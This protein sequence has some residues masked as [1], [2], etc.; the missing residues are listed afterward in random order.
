MIKK[1]RILAFGLLIASASIF[2]EDITPTQAKSS[3][4]NNKVTDLNNDEK[5]PFGDEKIETI[6]QAKNLAEKY[7]KLANRFNQIALQMQNDEDKKTEEV[8]QLAIQKVQEQN[9]K[10]HD[11]GEVENTEEATDLAGDPVVKQIIKEE[12]TSVFDGSNLSFGGNNT[13]GNT[14]TSQVSL[15]GLLNYIPKGYNGQWENYIKST[16]LYQAGG[17][18]G[19]SKA[20]QTQANRFYIAQN[21]NYFFTTSKRNGTTWQIN[22][23]N[24]K[25]DGFA[26][27]ANEQIGYLRRVLESD[28]VT[29][30][31]SLGPGMQQFRTNNQNDQ[32]KN[33]V[34][35]WLNMNYV[36]NI[37]SD[38]SFIQNITSTSSSQTTLSSSTSTIATK[39]WQNFQLNTSFLLSYTSK[40][41]SGK[42]PTNT[43][44]TIAIQYNF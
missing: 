28:K 8:T 34:S 42:V 23:L 27:V 14:E 16:Y 2:A 30:D 39:L 31:I 25:F 33:L 1:A 24:D 20:G 9:A 40:P 19:S 12:V 37:T 41:Q 10:E 38:T 43:T 18:R 36:W 17:T 32:F 3:N 6:Q 4:L 26:Y 5:L 22:Y 21:T 44:T 35:F 15:Q 7:Q 11:S 13:T 29:F